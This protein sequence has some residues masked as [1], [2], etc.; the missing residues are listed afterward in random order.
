MRVLSSYG[1]QVGEECTF[2]PLFLSYWFLFYLPV[3]SLQK[4]KGFHVVLDY[5]EN[6]LF[7]KIYFNFLKFFI[8]G[9]NGLQLTIKHSSL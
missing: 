5:S 9:I 3:N 6:F 1:I 4:L 7:F 8:G 2:P